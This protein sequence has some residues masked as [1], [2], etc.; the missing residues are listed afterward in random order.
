MGLYQK[1]TEK[2]KEINLLSITDSVLVVCGGSSDKDELLALGF[3]N[4][5]I[6]NVSPHAGVEDYHPYKWEYQDAEGLTYPDD[7]FDWVFVKAGLHH[8]ASP[9]WALCEMLRVSRKGVGVI[10]AQDSTLMKIAQRF[11]FTPTYEV[12]PLAISGGKWGGVRNT[13]IPNFI[14]RWTKQEVIK[15]VSSF[16]PQYQH[17]Y[18]FFYELAIPVERLAMSKNILIKLI[19]K[20][21]QPFTKIIEF[22]LKK[23]SNS[24]AFLVTKKGT[25]QPYLIEKE[26]DIDFNME[27]AQKVYNIGDYKRIENSK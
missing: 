11:N 15:T 9:H 7:S 20:I 3:K 19:A 22:F 13:N 8:C 18:Y 17:E 25:L 2:G 16:M 14:Y 23:Q 10:E 24:F 1:L 27:Y 26:C 12:E 6:S 5:I 21:A 4:V